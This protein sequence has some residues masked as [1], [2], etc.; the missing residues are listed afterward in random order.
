MVYV[1]CGSELGMVLFSR[2]VAFPGTF[3]AVPEAIPGLEAA[4]AAC[5]RMAF[6]RSPF[7]LCSLSGLNRLGST[8]WG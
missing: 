2:L 4:R 1:R 6:I 5:Q 7:I 8:E 3:R